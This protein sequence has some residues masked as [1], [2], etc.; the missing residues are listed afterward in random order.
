MH[1]LK[2]RWPLRSPSP[3]SIP[4]SSVLETTRSIC[5]LVSNL[6][7]GALN[8]PGLQAA[9]LIGCQIIDIIQKMKDNQDACNDL[10]NDIGQLMSPI[11]MRLQACNIADIDDELKADI[12][13]L[14][15]C[16]QYQSSYR[17]L[18]CIPFDG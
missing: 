6:G 16:V 4:S 9:G 17:F 5:V 3:T 12:K 13:R 10:V 11:N 15:E 1:K 8:V 2:P 14:E 18:T 7:S